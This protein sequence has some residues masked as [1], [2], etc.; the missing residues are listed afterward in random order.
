MEQRGL[1]FSSTFDDEDGDEEI[2]IQTML[3]NPI[4]YAASSDPD[5]MYWFESCV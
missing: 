4:A 3:S 1:V 5:T 2:Q